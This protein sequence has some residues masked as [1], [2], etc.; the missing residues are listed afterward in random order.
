MLE[1]VQAHVLLLDRVQQQAR[2]IEQLMMA[3]AQRPARKAPPPVLMQQRELIP[4]PPQAPKAPPPILEDAQ[5]EG[6]RTEGELMET[7]RS[8]WAAEL[9]E[10]TPPPN[11]PPPTDNLELAQQLQAVGIPMDEELICS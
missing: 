7:A 10:T 5:M 1:L 11:T 9:M 2:H 6:E 8:A 3:A 4:P